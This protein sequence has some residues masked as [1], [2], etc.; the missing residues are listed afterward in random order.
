M[1]EKES[2]S[3]MHKIKQPHLIKYWARLSWKWSVQEKEG[4]GI[5]LASCVA[6]FH[7][8]KTSRER[9]SSIKMGDQKRQKSILYI[10]TKHTVW[11]TFCMPLV[12]RDVIHCEI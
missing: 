7:F 9:Q 11:S 5:W 3:V 8:V 1:S 12:Y 2:L 4:R 6:S 10:P